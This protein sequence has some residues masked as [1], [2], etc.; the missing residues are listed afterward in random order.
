MGYDRLHGVLVAQQKGVPDEKFADSV[1][2]ESGSRVG[3]ESQG[4]CL[5]HI[6]AHSALVVSDMGLVI[7]DCTTKQL[8][9]RDEKPLCFGESVFQYGIDLR[10]WWNGRHAGLRSQCRKV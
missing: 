10:W 4:I 8:N 5:N 3:F 1:S 2:G 9:Q 6:E 7:S